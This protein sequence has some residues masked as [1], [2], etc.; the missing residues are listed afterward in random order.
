MAK[1]GIRQ[2]QIADT[3]GVNRSTV[4]RWLKNNI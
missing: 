2:Q 4:Y 1:K 3:L